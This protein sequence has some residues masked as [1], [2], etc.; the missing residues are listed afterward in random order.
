M[1]QHQSSEVVV[2]GRSAQY[3]RVE[4]GRV[5]AAEAFE[6]R[7]TC[8]CTGEAGL[9]VSAGWWILASDGASTSTELPSI[10]LIIPAVSSIFCLHSNS[11]ACF[12]SR[13]SHPQLI[14]T[15]ISRAV[16]F[17]YEPDKALIKHA[18]RHRSR[19]AVSDTN[20]YFI[21]FSLWFLSTFC[22]MS[23]KIHYF[24]CRRYWHMRS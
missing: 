5:V 8:T 11:E 20:T 7:S 6:V 13:G 15:G 18:V 24:R 12:T 14:L 17:T 19:S 1:A 10:V 23:N 3:N 21:I 16:L 4:L 22:M 9:Q 2:D